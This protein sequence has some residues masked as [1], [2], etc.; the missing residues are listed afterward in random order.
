MHT[1]RTAALVDRTQQVLRRQRGAEQLR[2]QRRN[3]LLH[4]RGA[5]IW[6]RKV[7][8]RSTARARAEAEEGAKDDAEAEEGG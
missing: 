4:L 8:A 7:R 1:H 6:A 5:W 3:R 2:P